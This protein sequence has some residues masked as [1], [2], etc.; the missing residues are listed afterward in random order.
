[1][2]FVCY[3]KCATCRKA[4]KWLEERGFAFEERNIKECSPSAEKLKNWHNQAVCR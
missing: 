3:P 4:R 1:M 2:Q